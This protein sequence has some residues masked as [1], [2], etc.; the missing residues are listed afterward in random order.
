MICQMLRYDP[1]TVPAALYHTFCYRADEEELLKT[2]KRR[3]I[4]RQWGMKL[5]T[6]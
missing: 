1:L 2:E 4:Y 3:E 5:F 6:N